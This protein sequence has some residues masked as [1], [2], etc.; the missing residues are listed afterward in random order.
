MSPAEKNYHLHSSKLELLALKWAVSDYFKDYL[1]HT[2][3]FIIYTDNNP[4]TYVLNT[5]K[6]NSTTHHW[7]AELAGYSFRPGKGNKAPDTLSRIS[8][9][10]EQFMK[11]CTL[12]ASEQE[13]RATISG[14]NVNHTNQA[15]WMSSISGNVKLQDIDSVSVDP[16]KCHMIDRNTLL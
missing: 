5:V 7:V 4:L 2:P 15:I 8:L 16:T 6:L 9:D 11:S 1:Y 12:E 10:I 14:L 13:I 3:S